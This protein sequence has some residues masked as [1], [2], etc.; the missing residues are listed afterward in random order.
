MFINLRALGLA[1]ALIAGLS[2]S[3]NM[4]CS[5]VSDAPTA[6]G[7][8][9]TVD[10]NTA[11][12]M[13]GRFI[14]VDG[15]VPGDSSGG[16]VTRGEVVSDAAT[17]DV[18]PEDTGDDDPWEVVGLPDTVEEPEDI[19]EDATDG[20][21]D[22]E[23]PQG[24]AEAPEDVEPVEDVPPPNPCELLECIPPPAGCAGTTIKTWSSTCQVNDAGEASCVVESALGDD[25]HVAGLGVCVDGQCAACSTDQQCNDALPP[26]P[27][28]VTDLVAETGAWAC[29]EGACTYAGDQSQCTGLTWSICQDNQVVTV[30]NRCEDQ[31]GCADLTVE[32]GGVQD[33]AANDLVCVQLDVPQCADPND[34]C[35][36]DDDCVKLPEDACADDDLLALYPDG[37]CVSD[38]GTQ[39]ICV[40]LPTYTSCA[41]QG[42]VCGP[43]DCVE[44]PWPPAPCDPAS[45]E[46]WAPEDGGNDHWYEA[47]LTP[48]GVTWEDANQQ[49][50]AMGGHLAALNDAAETIW[51]FQS[52][53][54]SPAL[55]SGVNG[56]WVGG[57][58]DTTSD[59][60]SEPAGGWTWVTGE[61]FNA[62]LWHVDQPDDSG[63]ANHMHY[64]NALAPSPTLGDHGQGGLQGF[65]VEYPY[66]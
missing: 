8:D 30:Q 55:W 17:P 31:L 58:Q 50:E 12:E 36:V 62:T 26:G 41:A 33:C 5:N 60:Y 53:A 15:R 39:G 61:A 34:T 29:A 63:P 14:P 43:A 45:C 21:E 52:L 27:Y 56:P 40:Y 18:E 46:H 23:E 35:E 44:P 37:T 57:F 48:E 9:A 38:A 49:A 59:S 2:V 13:D 65:I 6:G 64:F 28:C 24:D 20:I 7:G 54:S 10:A 11:G 25:C 22:I 51:V 16:D 19:T 66:P 32:D 4:G 47:V 3:L 1:G 42:L